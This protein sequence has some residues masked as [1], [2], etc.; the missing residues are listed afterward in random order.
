MNRSTSLPV[1]TSTPKTIGVLIQDFCTSAQPIT[2]IVV[3]CRR[4][5]F[6]E[7]LVLHTSSILESIEE[8]GL[9]QHH[10][11]ADAPPG[12]NSAEQ[13]RSPK[14]ILAPLLHPT[15]RLLTTSLKTKIVFCSS[16]PS[17]RAHVSTLPL[18]ANEDRDKPSKVVIM[19]MLALH[20]GTSDFTIQGLS[21]T[22]AMLAAV[23]R[24]MPGEM[25]LVECNDARDPS[26]PQ[27][28]P[29]LWNAEVPLLSGS[30]K[31]GEAGQGWASRTTSIKSFAR[32]WFH[33]DS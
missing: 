9:Q 5:H 8:H 32:R 25:H 1:V 21:R 29:R 10:P 3:C 30:V 14:H 13:P 2:T 33:F 15:L 24:Q 11:E 4:S 28:G 18:R 16:I 12:D 17:F 31:I 26:D 27:R 22:F 23:H 20:H 6:F 19:D 7:Q